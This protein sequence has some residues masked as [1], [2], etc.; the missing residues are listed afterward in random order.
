METSLLTELI[1]YEQFCQSRANDKVSMPVARSGLPQ[2]IFSA[3]TVDHSAKPP[4]M[5]FHNVERCVLPNPLPL[6]HRYST[7]DSSEIV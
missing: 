2:S 5:S 4:A 3:T 7:E 6:V 1:D